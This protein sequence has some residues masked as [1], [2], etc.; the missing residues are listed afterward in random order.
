MPLHMYVSICV[1]V[2]A[3]KSTVC[4][5]VSFVGLRVRESVHSP[6]TVTS[7]S[8]VVLIVQMVKLAAPTK[9]QTIH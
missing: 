2:R 9:Q 7:P 5:G 1:H 6:D 8:V 3:C 4:V